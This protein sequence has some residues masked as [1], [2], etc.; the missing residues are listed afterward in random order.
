MKQL[1]K[2]ERVM[3]TMRFQDT[4]RVPVYDILQNNAVI[5]YYAGQPLTVEK[6]DLVK[7]RAI[8]R[9]LDMTRMP[10]G[11]QQSRTERDENDL[12]IQYEP[13]TSW[14]IERPFR[15][16]PEF[17]EWV[18][19]DIQRNHQLSY[20]RAF[21]VRFHRRIRDYQEIFAQADPTGRHDPTVMIVESGVGLTEPYWMAG[22][23]Y[24]SYLL[25]DAPDLLDEWLESRN[26]AEL[27]RVVAIADPDVIPL[28][29]TYDD[30]AY[31][32]ALLF[33]PTWLRR[34]WLP[35]LKRLIEAWHL[36]DTLCIYHSDGN[37]WQITDDL[38]G[39]GIDGLN[40]LE[41]MAGM[42]VEAVRARYPHLVL[43]GGIDVSDLLVYGTPD[44]VR[45]ACRAAI[46]ATGGR[47]YFIGSSTEL[48]WDVNLE[49]AIAMFETAWQ[50]N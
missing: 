17:I 30:I 37:L 36:R 49:N 19:R 10:E 28:A 50:T 7:G 26:Q 12:L 3:R 11:P 39:A 16:W 2:R 33:S 31:K 29:L 25:A 22:F 6:G 4:D 5:E 9:V 46:A 24:F 35:R 43:T 44:D 15:D 47:G 34:F 1:T 27:R 23:E 14:I 20:D 48:H 13:W 38:V 42:T 45:A 41:V 40:P 21:A 18:K 8:G 32:T